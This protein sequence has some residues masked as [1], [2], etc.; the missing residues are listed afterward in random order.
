MIASAGC[1]SCSTLPSTSPSPIA[2][3]QSGSIHRIAAKLSGAPTVN[4][5]TFW[6]VKRDGIMVPIDTLRDQ[7]RRTAETSLQAA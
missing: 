2:N 1:A 5:W 4:G 3:G 7:Y 6:Q